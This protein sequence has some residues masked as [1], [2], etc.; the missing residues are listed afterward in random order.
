MSA[1]RAEPSARVRWTATAFAS[2]A[3]IIDHCREALT[4]EYAC[5]DDR[6]EDL[7]RVAAEK[8]RA[9]GGAL[10]DLRSV[11]VDGLPA[12]RRIEELPRDQGYGV[13]L[14][15]PYDDFVV[16]A[17]IHVSSLDEA[18]RQVATLEA[19]LRFP[20]PAVR[21]ALTEPCEEVDA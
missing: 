13:M 8:T 18:D 5:R 4:D 9:C 11:T 19:N 6:W 15:I 17:R 10:L 12:V 2:P 3:G 14:A 1:E 21:G 20:S 16:V 7:R